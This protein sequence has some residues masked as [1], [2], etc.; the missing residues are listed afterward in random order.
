[1]V[2]GRWVASTR[3]GRREVDHTRDVTGPNLGSEA[4]VLKWLLSS[5]GN[6]A[7]ILTSIG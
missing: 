7:Q 6:C 4:R 1:M 2:D 3:R 5:Q